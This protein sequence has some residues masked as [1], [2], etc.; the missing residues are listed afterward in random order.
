MSL[1]IDRASLLVRV[2]GAV[3]LGQLEAALS[4]EGLT[5]GPWLTDSMHSTNIADWI[6]RG[7]PGAPSQFDDPADHLLA[8]LSCTLL[9][10]RHL[11]IRPGPRRAVGP[12]LVALVFG[13]HE[14]FATLDRAWLRVH[15]KGTQVRSTK[16]VVDSDPP[17]SAEELTLITALERE[18][19]S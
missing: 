16:V 5:L 11:D 9:D 18:L 12:D 10:G 19:R 1:E 4:P 17:I 6:A 15:F 3:T 14:R 7:A 2:P 8:G 13:A